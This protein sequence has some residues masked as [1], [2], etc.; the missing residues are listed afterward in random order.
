MS[1][2]VDFD[3]LE[4]AI[5]KKGAEVASSQGN[6]VNEWFQSNASKRCLIHAFLIQ[7]EL[8]NTSLRRV[9]A[10]HVP[11]CVFSAAVAWSVYFDYVSRNALAGNPAEDVGF[12]EFRLIDVHFSNYWDN[13][14]G[15]RKGNT[16]SIKG[17][18][19]C[20]LADILRRTYY[21]GIAQKFGLILAPLI[22]GGA[23]EPPFLVQ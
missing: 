1:L 7:R 5:G 13:I 15:M 17:A 2:C 9:L 3:C 4:K 6:Y 21:W 18:T 10:I 19:L 14:M 12:P 22:H 20:K 11:R 23:D 16:S 8:E